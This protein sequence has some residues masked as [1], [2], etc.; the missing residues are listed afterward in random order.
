MP[1]PVSPAIVCNEQERDG[2]QRAE[3][4]R[5]IASEKKLVVGL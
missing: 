1:L 4:V 2:W 5:K 3:H